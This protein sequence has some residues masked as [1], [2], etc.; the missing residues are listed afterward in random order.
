MNL[1]YCRKSAISI[2]AGLLIFVAPGVGAAASL[3]GSK[4]EVRF[5]PELPKNP[6]DPCTKAYNAYV[7]ASGHSAY[8]TTPYM[9]VG[10]LYMICGSRVNAPSQ[11]AAEDAALKSC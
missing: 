3:A 7:A 11:K 6:K 8:A 1:K 10:S 5:W 4:G 9:R 2:L